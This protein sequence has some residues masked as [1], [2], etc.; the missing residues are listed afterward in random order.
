M[1]SMI[2][3]VTGP[4]SPDE[5][6][7]TLM[8]EHVFVEY[9]TAMQDNRSLGAAR[10]QILSTC[11]D[12]AHQVKACGVATVVDPTTTDL[13]RNIPL[14]VALAEQADLQIVCCT[15]IY[16]TSTYQSLRLQL[17]GGPDTIAD[18]FIKEL[19][20]GIGDSG[21]KAGI[22]KLVSGH[23]I[24]DDDHELLTCCAKA[25]VE[26][27]APIITHTE[28]VLGPK[29]QEILH[30][31]GVPLEKIIV[32]H[33]CISTNFSYH[34]Q[35][36][37][38]GS[39]VGFDRFGM[40]GGMPDEVRVESLKKLIDAG[41][42]DKLIVSHDSVWYWVNGPKIG[43]G[44]YK[45]WKPTNFFERVMPMLTYGGVSESQI[46]TMLTDNPRRFFS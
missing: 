10:P 35:I 9:G 27:G 15:G 23:D 5:L 31:A 34:Q 18:L 40:E 1:G 22:I 36:A 25:S 44:P 26:T 13:G 4:I 38:A 30:T 8:H 20:E 39:Y 42:L 33:S 14:L 28:G 24:D 16:S 21:V 6:G 43:Q 29:Q 45:N 11:L 12:F 32:G 37:Q 7:R 46:E 3:T 17:G 41:F 2:N 19:T